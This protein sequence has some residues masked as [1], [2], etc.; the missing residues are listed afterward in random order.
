M[1]DPFAFYGRMVSATLDMIGTAHRVSQT[2]AASNEVIGR[3]TAMM[4]DAAYSPLDGNYAE[5]SRMV[6]EK[7][8]AF[9]KAGAAITGDWWA[10]Q[11][12]FLAQ[13]QKFGAVATRGRAPSL[14]E[15]SD[16]SANTMML[17]LRMFERVGEM[18][19]KGLKP[20]HAS[21]TGN[22]RRLKRVSAP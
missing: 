3:R 18:G 16:L 8:A 1:L 10:M 20:I 6:P 11:S 14:V 15:L 19:A 4:R 13:A 2:M 17:G 12:A 22:A 5:L 9:G 7:I 21:A